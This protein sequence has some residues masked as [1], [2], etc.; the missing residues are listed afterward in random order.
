MI[1]INTFS[2]GTDLR[3]QNLSSNVD[4]RTEKIAKIVMA[5]DL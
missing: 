2:A 3:R 5:V 4:P 1:F